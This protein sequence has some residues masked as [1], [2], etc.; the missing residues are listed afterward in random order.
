MTP[1]CGVAAPAPGAVGES[2]ASKTGEAFMPTAPPPGKCRVWPGTDSPA[3]LGVR[4]DAVGVRSDASIAGCSM[5]GSASG[6]STDCSAA[7]LLC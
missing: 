1:G 6:G 3:L 4:S 7:V 2:S 5:A